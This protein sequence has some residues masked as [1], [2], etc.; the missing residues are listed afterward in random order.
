MGTADLRAE[1]SGLLLRVA[2]ILANKQRRESHCLTRGL[3][4][5][6][7][8]LSRGFHLLRQVCW[9][10]PSPGCLAHAQVICQDEPEELPGCTGR[11]K[12]SRVLRSPRVGFPS[13]LPSSSSSGAPGYP[14]FWN[15]PGLCDENLPAL[16]WLLSL[17]THCHGP[18]PFYLPKCGQLS[19]AVTS[20]S[21]FFVLARVIPF[22]P[23]A[24][25]LVGFEVGEETNA[26]V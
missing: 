1:S 24:V 5:N 18:S 25:T 26:C 19:S 7:S 4:P 2:D 23:F 15:L 22:Y 3:P 14:S 16:C 6:P 8:A 13:A 9:R 12:G 10:T 11:A 17:Q 20:S 21:L